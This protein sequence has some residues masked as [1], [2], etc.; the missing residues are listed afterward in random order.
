MH[1]YLATDGSPTAAEAE[2]LLA[3]FPFAEPPRVTLATV[4]P[5]PDLHAISSDVTMPVTELVDQCRSEA[6][7]LL[8]QKATRCQEWAGSV[9]TLLLAGHPADELLQSIESVHPDVVVVGSRGLGAVRRMLLGSVSERIVKHAP[10]SVLVAHAPKHG[11]QFD[12][13]LF[14]DDGSKA[15]LAGIDRFAPLL[16]GRRCW[17]E[18]L[19]VVEQISVYG[20]DLAMEADGGLQQTLA[21]NLARLK[22]HAAK[23]DRD[24]AMIET[25]VRTATDVADAVLHMAEEKHT[26]LIVVGSRGKSVWERFLLGSVSLGVLHHMPC[27]VWIE[28]VK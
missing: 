15:A 3:K 24:R 13:F 25:S 16:K 7:K 1:V 10:C 17:I 12:S 9:E 8:S 20:M 14:A 5:V 11:L 26:D 21:E 22:E 23:F 28:R 6:T 18:L 4:C 27:S 19:S 2:R